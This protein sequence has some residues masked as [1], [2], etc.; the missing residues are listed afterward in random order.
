VLQSPQIER[1]RSSIATLLAKELDA[2][3]TNAIA[4]LTIFVAEKKKERSERL[5][6]MKKRFAHNKE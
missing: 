1:Q 5:L 4:A 3:N 2:N 6:L